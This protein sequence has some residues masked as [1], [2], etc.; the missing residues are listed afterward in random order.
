MQNRQHNAGCCVHCG[1]PW[2]A[3]TSPGCRE[4]C[5]E[6]QAFLHSCLNCR[7][8]N[9]ATDRCSSVTAECTG[10]REHYNYCEEYQIAQIPLPPRPPEDHARDR[11][12]AL[13]QDD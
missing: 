11:W 8:Y 13:F 9:R 5:P 6:C 2:E 7:L 10:D 3:K 1:H 4:T 12:R